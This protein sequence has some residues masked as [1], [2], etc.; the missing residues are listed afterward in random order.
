MGFFS[1]LS[2]YAK[3]VLAVVLL[4]SCSLY[5][6]VAAVLLSLVGK[7]R[8]AQWTTAR[9]FN[10]I[11]GPAIGVN[12]KVINA[13]KIKVPAVFVS[14]HQ[15]ELDILVLGKIF[16]PGCTVTAKES[17][18]WVPL[19]GWF[20]YLS[21][22]VF[23]N[24]SN[25]EKSVGTLKS[26]L[27]SLK[28][29]KRAL[30]IYPEGTRSYSTKLKM[31][32]FK[33]GAFHLAQQAQIPIIPVVVSNTSTLFCPKLGIFNSGVMT[34]KVLDPISTQDL[35]KEDIGELVEDVYQLMQTEYENMGYSEAV[36]GSELPP[37]AQSQLHPCSSGESEDFKEIDETTSLLQ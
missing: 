10:Y 18:K 4:S 24:R 37:D 30:W 25:R 14:N 32:P 16:V 12:V 6:V 11:V 22:T 34:C 26:A 5:G 28:R 21:G 9:A 29:D 3:S 27:E 17:L 15:S 31:L 7:R 1:K 35:K 19:L 23:L 8:L 20:M 33:K 13:D 36:P 2:F